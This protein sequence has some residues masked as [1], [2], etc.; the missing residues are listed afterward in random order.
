MVTQHTETQESGHV[1]IAQEAGELDVHFLALDPVVQAS[2]IQM[3]RASKA[4]TRYL[5]SP[6]H[7]QRAD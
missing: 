6:D 7:G 1:D 3:L 5:D 4:I 2:V